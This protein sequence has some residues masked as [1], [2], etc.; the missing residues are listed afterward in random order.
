MTTTSQQGTSHAPTIT[1]LIDQA[2][3]AGIRVCWIPPSDRR[4]A[5]YAEEIRTIWLRRD[6]TSAEARSLL[7]H[8]LAHAHYGDSGAQPPHR[9]AR[10]WRWAA[11]LLIPA[12]TYAAAEALVGHDPGALADHLGVTREIISAYRR[13]MGGVA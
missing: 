3:D 4:Q 5:I 8:E 2:V 7:A 12:G 1:Q 10:A 9:E 6:L 11:R 13:S